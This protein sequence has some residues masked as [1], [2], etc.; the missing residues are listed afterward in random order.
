MTTEKNDGCVLAT[1]VLWDPQIIENLQAR[2]EKNFTLIT[3]PAELTPEK[4]RQI[5]PRY[6]FFQHWSNRIPPEIYEQFESVVFHMT[7][8]PFGRGGSPLQNLIV[9]GFEETK[10]SAIRCVE[11][12]DAGPVYLKQKLKLDGS[13]TEIFQ[14]AANVIED[15]IVSILK[16]SPEPTPQEGTPVVFERRVAEDGNLES[17]K[18][19]KEMYNMIR[20]LDAETYPS[21]FLRIGS[22]RFEFTGASKH[23]DQVRANVK[24]IDDDK[25]QPELTND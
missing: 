3:D 11:E 20:M 2:S 8:L 18:N 21:A 5:N 1:R 16:N 13:A 12:I 25:N 4:L 22:F 19:L 24:I 15:M 17:A 23:E 7:D 10:I 14:R 6:V 9:R